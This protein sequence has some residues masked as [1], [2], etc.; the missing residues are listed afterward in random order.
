[1]D[2]AHSSAQAAN[3]LSYMFAQRTDDLISICAFMP[4]KA[5]RATASL[6]EAAQYALALDSEGV[7]GTYVRLT[8]LPAGWTPRKPG[9]RG[10]ATESAYMYALGLDLDM[11]GPG[12]VGTT[13]PQTEEEL[14]QLLDRAGLPRPSAWVHSGG[15]RY[16]FWKL[17][18]RFTVSTPETYERGKAL[19]EGWHAH[20]IAWANAMGWK[21]DNTRDLARVYRLPGT[22][23]RKPERGADQ[24]ITYVISDD[25][26][27]YTLEDLERALA[28]APKPGGQQTLS[29]D[30]F[31]TASDLLFS[32]DYGPGAGFKSPQRAT[33]QHAQHLEAFRALT[34]D[35]SA[36]TAKLCGMAM[37]VGRGVV[38]GFWDETPERDALIDACAAN[39]FTAV[40]GEAY[41]IQQIDRGIESGKAQPWT[42]VPD[43]DDSAAPVLVP[44]NLPIEFWEARDS[45]RL[46][47]ATA[48]SR[49]RSAD[50]ALA[51]VLAYYAATAPP[52]HGPDTGI[53]GRIGASLNF[54]AAIVSHTGAGKSTGTTVAELLV[55]EYMIEMRDH[56]QMKEAPL[57]S[58]EGLAEAY[59]GSVSQETTDANGKTKTKQVRKKV[60]DHALML[61][62]EGAEMVAV[63]ERQGATIGEAMRSAWSGATFGALNGRAETTRT[64]NAGTY[65]LGLIAGFQEEAAAPLF[66]DRNRK[67]G[68]TQRFL[69]FSAEDPT[70]TGEINPDFQP[71]RLKDADPFGRRAGFTPEKM[72]IDPDLRAEIRAHDTARQRGDVQVEE[73]DSQKPLMLIKVASL[74]A[75]IES[76]ADVNREDW[77]LAEAIWRTSRAVCKR[78]QECEQRRQEREERDSIKRQAHR[79]VGVKEIVKNKNGQKLHG[80]AATLARAVHK[81]GRL[82]PG[83]AKATLGSNDRDLFDEACAYAVE[84]DWIT[85][86]DGP[87]FPGSV[88]PDCDRGHG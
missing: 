28:A 50:V 27:T 15:G 8:T 7:H 85:V 13:Y 20:V 63:M 23:N 61:K 51:A 32:Q 69:F 60:R 2:S 53:G 17:A 22:H 79:E 41:V 40:K 58:G 52:W 29:G 71:A 76:R 9:S 82:T 25:G 11:A 54:F 42:V 6:E 68:M 56:G 39:G 4:D 12:H 3:F 46:I 49:N 36:R 88:R 44:R 30:P 67:L 16:P 62:D 19:S 74:L 43:R 26:P 72:T 37:N 14:H 87:L 66:S 48:H 38:A 75:L 83:K 84:Q 33:V 10:T 70:I 65:S 55:P 31:G 81:L 21:I 47:R 73:L 59:M 80:V 86:Q 18:E 35:N 57:G 1:M 77:E 78:I 45:L 5:H 34:T 24:P 64:I